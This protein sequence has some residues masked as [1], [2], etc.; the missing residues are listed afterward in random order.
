G[1][2]H[3]M[4]RL[5]CIVAV[6]ILCASSAAC[7]AATEDDNES[8]HAQL[9]EAASAQRPRTDRTGESCEI[10]QCNGLLNPYGK[11]ADASCSVCTDGKHSAPGDGAKEPCAP[12]VIGLTPISGSSSSSGGVFAP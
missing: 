9:G 10:W 12:T 4:N 8:D 6:G 7:I 5:L 11:C 1:G 2:L 3:T